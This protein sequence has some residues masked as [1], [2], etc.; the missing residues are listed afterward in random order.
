MIITDYL[1]LFA[2]KTP[3]KIAV[4][5]IENITYKKLFQKVSNFSS[6][7]SNIPERSVVSLMFDNSI[8]FLISY[9]GTVSAG[10]VA[11]LISTKI[12][13]A[14]LESQIKS[15][16][17]E[18]ILTKEKFMREFEGLDLGRGSLIEY[19][20]MEKN[21]DVRINRKPKMNDYAYLL[22][23]SGTTS[24]PKGVAITHSQSEFTTN[25]IIKILGYNSSDVNMVP[26]P[27]FH[28]FGLGCVHTSIFTGA[29]LIIQKNTSDIS[30]MLDIIENNEATTFATVPATLT[31][32]LKNY[33]KKAEKTFLNLR[34]IMTNSTSIP[35]TT[36]K[37]YKKILKN[38]HLATYYGLT[39]A[40][41]STFMVF[42]KDIEKEASV[43][44]PAPNVQI[45][46]VRKNDDE[47]QG[48]ILI[49]G[50][51]VIE[52]Y[53]NNVEA[54]KKIVSGW[55]ETGDL[56]TIDSEGYLYLVGR[57]DDIIN[58][59]GNKVNPYEIEKIVKELSGI[60]EAII[61][62]KK[63]EIFGN[64]IKLFIK[65]S[66]ISEIKKTD[67]LSYCIKN[68]ERYKVPI[69]IEFIDEFP[70]TEYGKIKRFMLQE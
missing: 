30:N 55:L 13:K 17:P 68:M 18:I 45:K 36:V 67:V 9:L 31:T 12:S 39:E 7:I 57:D 16:N 58:V 38:G 29:S 53:W 21:E 11:H 27:F 6:S 46:I 62:G 8:E 14:N 60:E 35:I 15:S 20:D 33:R 10:H 56:G 37:E 40:S 51:N 3:D 48:N 52:K 25:N 23:T 65:K 47:Q 44:I 70:R 22:F 59:A 1:Q 63:H 26:I 50:K 61:V 64:V 54:D 43:G 34:L 4:S 5:G 2:Q 24:E 28:S 66:G 19:S 69:D 49:K 41:R 42:K 32:I